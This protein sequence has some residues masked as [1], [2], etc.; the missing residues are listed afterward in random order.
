MGT[1]VSTQKQE[2]VTEV[3]QE[4]MNKNV[5]K[6]E[7]KNELSNESIQSMDVTF[8]K[9]RGC[10]IDVNQTNEIS[11]TI[12]SDN[13]SDISDK[14]SNETTAK[15]NAILAQDSAQKS[16]GVALGLTSVSSQSTSSKS[17]TKS[18]LKTI[19]DTTIT[20]SVKQNNRMGQHMVLDFDDVICGKNGKITIN[21]STIIKALSNN[22]SKQII[23]TVSENK[24]AAE[25]TTSLSQ[26]AIQSIEGLGG[27]AIFFIIIALAIVGSMVGCAV[28]P[29]ICGP[30]LSSLG[31]GKSSDTSS[32]SSSNISDFISKYKIPI[33]IGIFVL[34]IIII[35]LVIYNN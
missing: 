32:S 6:I 30:L 22:M 35:S 27:M 14:M 13:S 12:I 18:Q 20:N 19:I 10:S 5:K 16:S 8:K 23:Q 7:N 15:V 21:Q 34:L 31:I 9:I 25:A 2:Q 24:A 33:G 17:I 26:K 29:E 3:L 28:K 11:A 4:S 1:A